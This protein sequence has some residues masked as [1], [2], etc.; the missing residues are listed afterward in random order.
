MGYRGFE[1]N[2]ESKGDFFRAL[3]FADQAQ[4]LDF[5]GGEKIE[6]R[7]I[8]RVKRARVGGLG[9]ADSRRLRLEQDRLGERSNR[10]QAHHRYV[11]FSG[12]GSSGAQVRFER[13]SGIPNCSKILSHLQPKY[14]H[15]VP[16]SV[17][18]C[19]RSPRFRQDL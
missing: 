11:A 19:H 15:L 17:R 10:G 18:V 6:A 7:L 9:Q 5:A 16:K 4:D 3:A 1:G 2:A 13:E 14:A 8:F 12:S